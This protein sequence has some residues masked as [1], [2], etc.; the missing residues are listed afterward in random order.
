MVTS[1]GLSPGLGIRPGLLVPA[2]RPL[3]GSLNNVSGSPDQRLGLKMDDAGAPRQAAITV[4]LWPCCAG[5]EIEGKDPCTRHSSVSKELTA[6]VGNAWVQ[7][8][9]RSAIP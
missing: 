9:R 2:C 1:I 4:H 3:S 5:C 7:V 6:L 8:R